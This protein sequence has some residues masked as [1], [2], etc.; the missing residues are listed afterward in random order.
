[1]LYVDCE[2]EGVKQARR[3]HRRLIKAP[4]LLIKPQALY[5]QQ[6]KLPPLSK[7]PEDPTY[8]HRKSEA[9]VGLSFFS[10]HEMLAA[11]EGALL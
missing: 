10:F 7:R 8:E 9:D 5:P 4:I 1:M 11:S 2:E 3:M 6:V